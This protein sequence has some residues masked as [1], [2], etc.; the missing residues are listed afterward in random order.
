[1]F[2]LRNRGFAAAVR[3]GLSSAFCFL[4]DHKQRMWASQG[5]AVYFN[6]GFLNKE[7]FL[8]GK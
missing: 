1:M 8:D 6:S 3:A 5:K 7:I 4:G 2:Q